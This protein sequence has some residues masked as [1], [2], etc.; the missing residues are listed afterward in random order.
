MTLLDR[1]ADRWYRFRLRR[2]LRASG[3]DIIAFGL[4]LSLA[5]CAH[6]REL[7]HIAE[8]RAQ[9]LHLVLIAEPSEAERVADECLRNG[10]L[11]PP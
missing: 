3:A 1:I 7:E 2:L 11:L 9:C 6:R 5:G 8:V 4:V 10:G